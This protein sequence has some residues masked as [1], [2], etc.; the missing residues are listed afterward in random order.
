MQLENRGILVESS[1]VWFIRIL[2]R[3]GTSNLRNAAVVDL[4]LK[5]DHQDKHLSSIDVTFH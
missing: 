3:Q 4:D 5:A 2:Q 1:S